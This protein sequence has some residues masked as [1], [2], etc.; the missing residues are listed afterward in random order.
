MPDRPQQVIYILQR[1]L[2]DP[3][4]CQ[5]RHASAAAAAVGRRINVRDVKWKQICGKNDRNPFEMELK[6]GLKGC[7]V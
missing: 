1:P 5:W 3:A 7:K 2:R 6:I 4:C